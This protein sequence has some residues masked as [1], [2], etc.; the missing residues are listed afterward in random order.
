MSRPR[1]PTIYFFERLPF[2]SKLADATHGC[3]APSGARHS[4][5]S[6]RIAHWVEVHGREVGPVGK[7]PR[8][9]ALPL[10]SL[11]LHKDLFGLVDLSREVRRTARVRVVQNEQLPVRLL[12]PRSGA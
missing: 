8:R 6:R 7:I 11:A 12:D 2:V 5:L 10:S 1:N 9:A 4:S 3:E